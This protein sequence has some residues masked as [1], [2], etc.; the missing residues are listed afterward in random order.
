[1]CLTLYLIPPA[2]I[3]IDIHQTASR[4]FSETLTPF[5]IVSD[6]ISTAIL[7]VIPPFLLYTS[8]L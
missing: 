1:M 8:S 6:L 3:S 4:T 2:L 5:H 7:G